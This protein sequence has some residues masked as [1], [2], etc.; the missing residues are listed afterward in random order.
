MDNRKVDFRQMIK[1]DAVEYCFDRDLEVFRITK[2]FKR[3]LKWMIG[4][5]ML[6]D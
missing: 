4:K 3:C 5:G 1:R 6:A 2:K